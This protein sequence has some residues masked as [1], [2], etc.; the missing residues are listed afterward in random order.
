MVR[1]QGIK[2]KSNLWKQLKQLSQETGIQTN[3]NY[4]WA[5][6][7]SIQTE[8]KRIEKQSRRKVSDKKV[9]AELIS[10]KQQ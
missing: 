2:Q 5:N 10:E 4:R 6:V 3:L 9:W 8:I 7:Q 1:G